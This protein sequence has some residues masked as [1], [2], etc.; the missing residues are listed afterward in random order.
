MQ[1]STD[2][3]RPRVVRSNEV[4]SPKIRKPGR[5]RCAEPYARHVE[6][7]STLHFIVDSGCRRHVASPLSADGEVWG[8]YPGRHDYLWDR[9]GYAA[10]LVSEIYPVEARDNGRSYSRCGC[11]N[12]LWF[13]AA[14]SESF[15]RDRPSLDHFG[16]PKPHGIGSLPQR[17]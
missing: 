11:A 4:Q 9:H 17:M 10:V 12:I 1:T 13:R 7:I 2:G 14:S 8:P 3:H 15:R 5:Q 16:A 6:P